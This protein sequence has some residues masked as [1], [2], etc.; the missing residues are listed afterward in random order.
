MYGDIMEKVR[1][2][3]WYEMDWLGD[4]VWARTTFQEARMLQAK[5]WPVRFRNGVKVIKEWP[6]N[7]R[8]RQNF[9]KQPIYVE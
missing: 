9:Q 5:G 1:Q 8:Y 6:F 7:P 2:P 4:G 3:G